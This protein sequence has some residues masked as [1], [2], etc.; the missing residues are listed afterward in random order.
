[1]NP[2]AL[3]LLNLVSY[4]DP[5][6]EG[7]GLTGELEGSG[8]PCRTILDRSKVRANTRVC[9]RMR[10]T[11]NDEGHQG[12]ESDHQS[13]ENV[14]RLPRVRRSAP[15]ETHQE[16]EESDG[17]E[18]GAANVQALELLPAGAMHV[19]EVERWRVVAQC[20]NTHD[21]SWRK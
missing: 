15:A 12:T 8:H 7:F 16:Q 21:H 2:R 10:R 14:S 5:A 6:F 3:K 1:M 17:E 20:E 11:I 18:D 9:T 19:Q 13:G 4:A